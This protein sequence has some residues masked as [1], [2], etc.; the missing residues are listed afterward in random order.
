MLCVNSR[1]LAAILACAATIGA[2]TAMADPAV[3]RYRAQPGDTLIAL[4]QSLLEHP[5]DW[6]EV[7]KLNHI[8]NPRSIPVG[9]VI[10]IPTR[11]LR[12]QSKPGE[13][14]AVNG[15]AKLVSSGQATPLLARTTWTPGSEI[16][17]S[18]G[19]HVTV[20][21][22]DGSLLKINSASVVRLERTQHY[23]R[24]G[25]FSTALQVIKGRV[26]AAVAHLTGGE[27]RFQIKTPQ[28]TLGVRGTDF[29]VAALDDTGT[30]LGEV[31]TG[32]VVVSGASMAPKG[33][34]EVALKAGQGLVVA[35]SQPLGV[36]AALPPAPDLGALPSLHERPLVR[37]NVPPV[38]GAQSYRAQVA[39]DADFHQVVAEVTS[40][41]PELRLAGLADG[42]YHLRVR[43]GNAQGL[44][45]RDVQGRFTLK[46]RPEP[47]NVVSP[48]PK[49]KHRGHEVLLQWTEP[50]HAHRYHLQISSEGNW[51]HPM[52]NETSLST[53][54]VTRALPSGTYQWRLASIRADGD[55]GPFGDI[56]TFTLLPPPSALP[57]PKVDEK[58]LSFSW[59]GEPGQT[60]VLQMARD[61][62]FTQGLLSVNTSEPQAV[63]P[64]PEHGG[65]W[66]VRTQATDA[67]GYVGPFSAAQLLQLPTCLVDSQGTCLH[68]GDGSTVRSPK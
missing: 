29:R 54:S 43:A 63:V 35:A 6:P 30:S 4:G 51:D 66:W 45:G 13:V 58:N 9:H 36:P 41:T 67:D 21:L 10:L 39:L 11:L 22:A 34:K 46:A 55:H 12:W 47:P 18:A 50:E 57:P 17:T 5:S 61:A 14:I 37:L 49:T 16:H 8:R 31:L 32:M 20:K 7:Q 19:A 25:F 65:R 26:E 53:T 68:A 56:K 60:F 44:E 64:R 23:E 38:A 15:T 3:Y 27:P 2:S 33:R 28:A 62:A 1:G 52:V 42:L 59:S 40:V 24:P 48:P